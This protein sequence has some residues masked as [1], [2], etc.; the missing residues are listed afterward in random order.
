MAS[1]SGGEGF[2]YCGSKCIFEISYNSKLTAEKM[3]DEINKLR[4]GV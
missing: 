1:Y 3:K 4:L 2:G